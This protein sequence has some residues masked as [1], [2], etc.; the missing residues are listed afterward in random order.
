M[1]YTR[2]GWYSDDGKHVPYLLIDVDENGRGCSYSLQ[3]IETTD[4]EHCCTPSRPSRPSE[5]PSLA[6][7]LSLLA[8]IALGQRSTTPQGQSLFIDRYSRTFFQPSRS[9]AQELSQESVSRLS[10]LANYVH[11]RR[12]DKTYGVIEPLYEEY[13]A[14]CGSLAYGVLDA[15][16]RFLD[17]SDDEV[18]CPVRSRK[19]NL[20]TH[21]LSRQSLKHFANMAVPDEVSKIVEGAMLSCA[22]RDHSEIQKDKANVRLR[23][24]LGTYD[25]IY[26]SFDM[27]S[28]SAGKTGFASKKFVDYLSA[29]A[30]ASS[31]EFWV[32]CSGA[33][34]VIPFSQYREYRRGKYEVSLMSEAM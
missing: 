26:H 16:S 6:E 19:H 29:L 31:S 25:G 20:C 5:P 23:E 2:Y 17:G 27:G 28:L 11:I 9:V 24:S 10:S 8:N 13:L 30:D 3:A 14:I 7:M 18:A 21:P 15:C 1:Y 22:I 33:D 12:W 4:L 34:E 32:I